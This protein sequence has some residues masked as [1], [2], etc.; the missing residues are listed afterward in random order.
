MISEIE[1]KIHFYSLRTTLSQIQQDGLI[2]RISLFDP[3]SEQ[4]R[5]LLNMH[6]QIRIRMEA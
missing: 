2:N 3:S 1:F 4:L 6:V 5:N